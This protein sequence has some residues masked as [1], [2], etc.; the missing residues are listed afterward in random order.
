VDRRLAAVQVLHEGGDAALVLE[1]LALLVALVDE[2]DAHAGVQ[3]R[4]LAQARAR[5]S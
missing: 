1:H 2:L 3:E 4:Q 5:I